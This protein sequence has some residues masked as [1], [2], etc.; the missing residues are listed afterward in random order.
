MQTVVPNIYPYLHRAF[1]QLFLTWGGGPEK[2]LRNQCCKTLKLKKKVGLKPLT[3]LKYENHIVS[4]SYYHSSILLS[5]YFWGW[6]G[7]GFYHNCEWGHSRIFP[8]TKRNFVFM[9]ILYNIKYDPE[10]EI[11]ELLK[12]FLKTRLQFHH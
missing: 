5:Y 2:F 3:T 12:Y 8:K 6:G 9:I 4:E 10:E 7:L 1:L 11:D